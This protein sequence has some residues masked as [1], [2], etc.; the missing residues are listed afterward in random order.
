VSGNDYHRYIYDQEGRKIRGNFEAAYANCDDVWPTQHQLDLPHFLYVKGL[1]RERQKTLGRT[2]RV[3]DIGCGYGDL[4]HE[5]NGF[6]ECAAVGLEISHSAALKGRRCLGPDLK[7]AV[8]DLNQGLPVADA[9]F[10]VV[11]VLGVFWFLLDR[12]RFCLA[13]LDRVAAKRADVVFTLHVPEN[14][15]G[16]EVIA[17][18]DDFLN[19]LRTQFDVVDGFKFYQPAALKALKPL[20]QTVDDVL[21]RCRRNGEG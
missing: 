13:E 16:K 14:P 21:I 8:G 4:V 3:L 11:L 19:L 5:L 6:A 1:V 15:I 7:I 9:T 12:A 18:Y 20:G 17:S 2:V 10:D